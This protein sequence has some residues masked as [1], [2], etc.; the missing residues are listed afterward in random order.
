V[1]S[2]VF[3]VSTS[4]VASEIPL[5]SRTKEATTFWVPVA[6]LVDLFL[7]RGLVDVRLLG[8]DQLLLHVVQRVLHRVHGGVGDVDLGRAEA[9]RVLDGRHGVVVGTHGGRDRPVGGV[10]RGFGNAVA[11]GDAALRGVKSLVGGLEGLQR[12]HRAGIGVDA[13]HGK[14]APYKT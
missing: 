4:M 7:D 13:R 8:G 2:A 5:A 11:G 10:V 14:Y 1:N 3:A 12:G 9:E 6:E